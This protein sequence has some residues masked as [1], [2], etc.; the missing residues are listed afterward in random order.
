MRWIV[1]AMVVLCCIGC[2]KKSNQATP[3]AGSEAHG[4]SATPIDASSLPS[5]QPTVVTSVAGLE[6]VA[7]GTTPP[8]VVRSSNRSFAMRFAK[9][10]DLTPMSV[11]SATGEIV[12]AQAFV[13]SDGLAITLVRMPLPASDGKPLDG[14]GL[15]IAYDGMGQQ[16]AENLG[17]KVSSQVDLTIDGLPARRV[18]AHVESQGQSISNTQWLIYQPSEQVIYMVGATYRAADAARVEPLAEA[19]VADLKVVS[20]K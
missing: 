8:F 4:S 6:L 12:A 16:G 7:S 11:A 19:I 13:E 15:R 10:P 20:G 2:A 1:L 5:I 14:N 18:T 17:G 3:S 9:K